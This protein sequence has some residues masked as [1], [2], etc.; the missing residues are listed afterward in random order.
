MTVVTGLPESYKFAHHQ[1]FDVQTGH[2]ISLRNR[3]C[4]LK[5]H[6]RRMWI[7][8]YWKFLIISIFRSIFLLMDKYSLAA[9]T[10]L[11]N[12][13][14]MRQF[15]GVPEQQCRRLSM[16]LRMSIAFCRIWAQI[17]NFGLGLPSIFKECGNT[18]EALL[19]IERFL[20]LK[21]AQI[22]LYSVFWKSLNDGKFSTMVRF[23]RCGTSRS[24]VASKMTTKLC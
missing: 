13:G 4:N 1:Q 16:V 21:R 23:L 8:I 2:A 17:N 11:T 14:S 5:H 3:L 24:M 9:R 20:T 15:T 7:I 19:F 12:V 10:E 18:V 22:L 6:F